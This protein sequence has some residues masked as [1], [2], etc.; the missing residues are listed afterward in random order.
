MEHIKFN[1]DKDTTANDLFDP[2]VVILMLLLL[3][4]ILVI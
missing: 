4:N 3:L 2:L 1:V